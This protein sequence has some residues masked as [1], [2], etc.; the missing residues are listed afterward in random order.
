MSSACG[1]TDNT[2]S[3]GTRTARVRTVVT[4]AGGTGSA[5]V[6]S[7]IA[8]PSRSQYADRAGC[9][10]PRDEAGSSGSWRVYGAPLTADSRALQVSIDAR[11][12]VERRQTEA[13]ARRDT[14]V[15]EGID[16]SKGL[17]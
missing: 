7:P 2:T 12:D 15:Q 1:V 9:A 17:E 5:G 8:A 4:R 10:R 13:P 3:A 11:T 14:R 6:G 16:E